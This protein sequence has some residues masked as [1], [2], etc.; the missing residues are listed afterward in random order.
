QACRVAGIGCID[1]KKML[2]ARVEEALAPVHERMDYY[3]R[4]VQ[5]IHDIIANGNKQ[6]TAIARATLAEVR[7]AVKI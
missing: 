5:E 1:C 4:N 3:Q 6:A 7:D 2:A